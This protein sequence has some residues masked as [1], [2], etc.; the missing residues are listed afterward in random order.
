MY[1][2]GAGNLPCPEEL[3]VGKTNPGKGD[4]CIAAGNKPGFSIG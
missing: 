2:A 4:C 1:M 3:D